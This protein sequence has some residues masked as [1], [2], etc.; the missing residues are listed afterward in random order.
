MNP[1]NS[2]PAVVW[3]ASDESKPV[4][5]QVLRM[6]GNSLCVYEPWRMGEEFFS[7]DEGGQPDPVGPR[8]GRPHPGPVRVPHGQPWHR[9][10]APEVGG[11]VGAFPDY[12]TIR[13][14]ERDGV[15]WVTLNRPDRHNAFNSLM[16]RELHDCW[17]TLRRRDVG[18]VRGAHRRR[19]EGVLHRHRPH[20]ADGRRHRRDHR[21]DR[22]RVAGW[23]AVHVQRPGRQHRP[24][25]FGSVEAGDR[26]G[27]RHGVRRR[28][29]HA[30]RG[31]VHHRR[32]ARHVLRPARDLRDD[33]RVRADPHARP[34]AVRRDHAPLAAR[35]L[36]A[37]V[38]GAGLRDRVGVA[39][40]CRA[41][42]S[43]TRRAGRPRRS[44]RSPRSPSRGRCGPSGR[45]GSSRTARRS[46]SGYAFVGLGTDQASIAEGQAF[47][48]SGK[49]ID[50]RLR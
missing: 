24:Q 47:F 8:P 36:R 34:H 18:A 14:E 12:E 35:Q 10:A 15:A 3:L 46:R 9:R 48:E 29:L 32:G 40:S 45:P 17:R 31:R 43:P 20:G 13:Y 23:H 39:R 33:R 50:W 37:A 11:P 19:R 38:R 1:G 25:E 30:R 4:T 27:E 2:A 7:T 5:G 42:S 49:R 28:V 16:Q 6:V 21:P 44:P 22:G 41:W 26:G